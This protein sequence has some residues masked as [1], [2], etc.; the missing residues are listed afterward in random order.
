MTVPRGITLATV[1][2]KAMI[3]RLMQEAEGGLLAGVDVRYAYHKDIGLRGIYGGGWRIEQEDAVAE[4]PGVLIV[5]TVRLALY[6]RVVARPAGD[7]EDTDADAI[8][9]GDLLVR[10]LK[11]DPGLAGDMKWLGIA[12]GFGDYQQTDDETISTHAYQVRVSAH[13]AY[14]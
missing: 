14:G 2:K 7:V 9:I 4:Q 13:L 12:S 5:E 10:A 6:V 3:R 1:A 11:A 8:A